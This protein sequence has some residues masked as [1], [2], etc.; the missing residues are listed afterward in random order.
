V[1]AQPALSGNSPRPSGVPH[2]YRQS[3]KNLRLLQMRQLPMRRMPL[4][5]LQELSVPGMS[6]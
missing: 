2:E 6:L 5:R 3:R 1:K 4:L